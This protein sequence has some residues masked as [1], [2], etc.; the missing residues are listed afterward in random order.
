ME[1]RTKGSNTH[2]HKKKLLKISLIALGLFF[3]YFLAGALIPYAFPPE[4]GKEYK[5]ALDLEGVYGEEKSGERVMLI[6]DNQEALLERL[7]LISMAEKEII[8]STFDFIDDDSGKDILA[9][10][11]DAAD[12]GVSV[13]V[14]VDGSTSF[15]HMERSPWFYALSSHE[16]AEIK[17][18]NRINPL[19]PWNIQGRMH[20]KY[21]IVDDF[22]YILGGRNTYNYFLGDYG[23]GYKNYDREL[24]IVR[25]DKAQ[26]GSIEE[27]K[28]YFWNIWSLDCSGYFHDSVTLSK[29]R[30]VSEKIAL[31]KDRYLELQERYPEAFEAKSY[32]EETYPCSEVTLVSNPVDTSIKEPW[33]FYAITELMKSAK[34]EVHIHSPYIV[35]ND[36]MYRSLEEIARRV[37]RVTLTINSP[38]NGGN[39]IASSDYLREKERILDTG[40]EVYEYNGGLSY[41]G[42]TILMDNRLSI[43]GSFNLDMRS[44]YLDTELMLVVDCVELN[45]ELRRNFEALERDSEKVLSIDVN[46]PAPSGVEAIASDKKSRRLNILKYIT[47]PFRFLI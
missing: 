20:D 19:T 32:M 8:L 12:R 25:E 1:F 24:L 29:E 10:L 4:I 13:K 7:R 23:T 21:L 40:L 30:E 38:A 6:E 37:P 11:Y 5:E 14:F 46:L 44:T 17:I 28:N 45:Q 41:H 34:E 39:L 3:I 43:V 15:L 27:L 26:G 9:A 18:Y 42:K 47:Y 31:L 16:K 36:Y 33:V 22:A 2:F 35:C